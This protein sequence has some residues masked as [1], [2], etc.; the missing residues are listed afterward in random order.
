MPKI[1]L[2]R[3]ITVD[4]T[5]HPA[6]AVVEVDK[7]RRKALVERGHAEDAEGFEASPS[8][9]KPIPDERGVK[10]EKAVRRP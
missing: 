6:G 8:P 3:E 5:T 1:Q 4:N 10:V 2:L 9:R 7:I